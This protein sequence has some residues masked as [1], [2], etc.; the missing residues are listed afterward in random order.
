MR[1]R[2][3]WLVLLMLIPGASACDSS[4]DVEP[5]DFDLMMDATQPY[6]EI[7]TAIDD[8]FVALSECVATPAAAMGFHYGHPARLQ[9]AT[10][11]ATLP[12]VLLYAPTSSGGKRL[13]GVE[14]M[15][16]GDAWAAAGNADPPTLAG[17]TFDAPDP[18]HP[19]A[20]IRPFHTLHV[21]IWQDNPDGMFAAFNPAITC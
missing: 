6:Q 8:G 4:V 15:V 3:T 1:N 17:R 20:M 11:D 14:F 10:I 13:V 7:Q 9:D 21:W 18:N 2:A 19:D 16:H 12:E 5:D